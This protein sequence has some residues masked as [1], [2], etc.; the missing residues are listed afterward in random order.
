MFVY[1][2]IYQRNSQ[3]IIF[4]NRKLKN[5]KFKS[6]ISVLLYFGEQAQ[7]VVIITIFF[8]KE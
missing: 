4:I 3:A 8:P 1:I 6:C 5:L 7:Q 2:Y